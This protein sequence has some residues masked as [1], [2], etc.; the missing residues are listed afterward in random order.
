MEAENIRETEGIDYS[1]YGIDRKQLEETQHNPVILRLASHIKTLWEAAELAKKPIE[2]IML[3]SLRQYNGKYEPSKLQKIL[4]HGG[5]DIYMRLTETKCRG[6]ASW[7]RDILMDEG[8]PPWSLEPTPLPELSD[9]DLQKIGQIVA[10]K[11]LAS[12]ELIGTAPDQATLASIEQVAIEEYRQ[13]ILQEAYNKAERMQIKI[14]DQLAQGG[15]LKAFDDFIND[16]VVFPCAFIKGPIV[17][18]QRKLSYAKDAEGILRAVPDSAIA[19]EFERVDPFNIYVEP[20][21]TDIDD[22]YLIEH[23]VMNDADLAGLIGIP[24][25]DEAAIRGLLKQKSASWLANTPGS[26]GDTEKNV[27]ENKY[28]T[29]VRPT[30]SYDALEFWGKIQGELLLEWGMSTDD[31]PDGT[32]PYDANVWLVGNYVIKAELNYDPLGAKP[33]VKTSMHKT[34]GAFWGRGVPETIKDVESVCN[35]AARALVNNMAIA[36]GPQV[37]IN[38]DRIPKD[39]KIDQLHPWNIHQVSSDPFGTNAPAVRFFQPDDNSNSLMNIYQ[40]YSQ[41][42]D[43]NSG[44]PAYVHGQMDVHGAGR[45]A[46]GLSMLMGSAGK[47]IRQIVRQI[48]QDIV[49][50]IIYK[51]FIYNM[52]YDSDNSIKG[53]VNIIAKGATNLA[54][55]EQANTR[56]IELLNIIGANPVLLESVGKQ[57]IEAALR[58][59]FK[60]VGLPTDTII[61]SRDRQEINNIATGL[62]G[63]QAQHLPPLQPDGA[64][65]GGQ[66]GNL[67]GNRG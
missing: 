8:A 9:E 62:A 60:D 54:I 44:I 51:E 35:A 40:Y 14:Q 12:I 29:H 49:K 41:V 46:S 18:N 55:K 25:F 42:A 32:K 48:D 43:D 56:R 13:E 19:P 20:G 30:G 63:Q 59:T 58:Q 3:D 31:I 21:I 52:R 45:T 53:D 23:H 4:K 27:L 57:G 10:D 17:R 39:A 6:A 50:P 64:P 5:S 15:W 36:S 65:Q 28:N 33:Y 11:T 24:G 38:I 26:G 7:L 61:P 1:R 34:P 67:V 66:D 2:T 47:V 22:G 37:E 16:L